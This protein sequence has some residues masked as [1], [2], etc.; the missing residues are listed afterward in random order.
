MIKDKILLSGLQS[1]YFIKKQKPYR[2][3]TEKSKL[4]H[5]IKIFLKSINITAK[6]HGKL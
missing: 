4:T 1:K 3:V 5:I 6:K 2:R